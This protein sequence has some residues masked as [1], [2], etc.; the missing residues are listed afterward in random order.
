VCV[1]AATASAWVAAR[2][3]CR[4]GGEGRGAVSR[5]TCHLSSDLPRVGPRS[6]RPEACSPA[7]LKVHIVNG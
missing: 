6:R 7:S 5:V 4:R 3:G 1:P 2:E